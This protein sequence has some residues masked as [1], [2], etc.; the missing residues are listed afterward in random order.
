MPIQSVNTCLRL[1][2]VI[3]LGNN[4]NSNRIKTVAVLT[5]ICVDSIAVSHARVPHDE[6]CI[7]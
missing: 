7:V 5:N 6:I 4:R 3:L 1:L 2:V